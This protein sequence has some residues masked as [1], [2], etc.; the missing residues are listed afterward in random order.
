MTPLNFRPQE[1]NTPCIEE[2]VLQELHSFD[3]ASYKLMGLL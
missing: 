2:N 3:F 1:T